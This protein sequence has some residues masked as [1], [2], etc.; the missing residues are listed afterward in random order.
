MELKVKVKWSR[1]WP[2]VAQRVGRGIALL[3]HDRGTRRGWVVSST[4]RPHFTPGKD[5]VTILQEVGWVSELAWTGG[6]SRPHGDSIPDRPACSQSLYGLSYRAHVIRNYE[7]NKVGLC[8][9]F[10]KLVDTMTLSNLPFVILTAWS[11][12]ISWFLI[13]SPKKIQIFTFFK[14]LCEP[15]LFHLSCID[16]L[17][18]LLIWNLFLYP[19]TETKAQRGSRD[20]AVLFR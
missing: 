3:F 8:A 9:N 7:C 19:R 15:R 5:P 12:M 2:A 1:Y 6:K 11:I 17:K 13:T 18:L 20:I 14:L 4:P 16:S 10:C